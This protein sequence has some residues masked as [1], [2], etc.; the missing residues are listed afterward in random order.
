MV[1]HSKHLLF[2]ALLAL[3][4][5][6]NSCKTREK[7][8]YFQTAST[9]S[10]SVAPGNYTPVFKTDDFLS[11]VVSGED[12]DAALPFNLPVTAEV[13]GMRGGYVAGI[14]ARTGYLIDALGNVNLPF[15]GSVHLAGLNRM[16]ASALL[17]TKLK[18]Y[19]SNPIVHIQIQNYKVTVLGDVR[20]P[21]TYIIPNERITVLEAIG[22]AGDLRLTG[23]RNN[24]LVIRDENGKKTEYRLDLTSKSVFASPA[25]YLTQNDV[26]YVEPNPAARTESTLWRTTGSFFLSITTL[27]I[28]TITLITR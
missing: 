23:L 5:Q 15:I 22:L 21:G 6:L 24:V 4:V 12:P 28:T 20:T 10:N 18:E 13:G 26:V 7:L 16:E 17:Q 2:T 27:V 9:D 3:L 1:L 19:L 14:P 8:V 25:Y 11:I